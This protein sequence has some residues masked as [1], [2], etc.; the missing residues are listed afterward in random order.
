[1]HV[2]MCVG[3]CA[4]VCVAGVR[5]SAFVCTCVCV[6]GDEVEGSLGQWAKVI[7]AA[8]VLTPVAT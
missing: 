8:Q 3:V 6:G 2:H 7:L 4:R 5:A 1:M